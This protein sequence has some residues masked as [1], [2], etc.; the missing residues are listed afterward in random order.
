MTKTVEIEITNIESRCLKCKVG[1]KFIGQ[2]SDKVDWLVGCHYITV[3][4]SDAE[5]IGENIVAI[6][7]QCE[8]LR[9]ID[10]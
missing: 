1:D 3:S 8:I 10:N 9:E 6:G 7:Y 4:D 5:I 2:L